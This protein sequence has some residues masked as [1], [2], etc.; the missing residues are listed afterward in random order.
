MK[1]VHR[2][3]SR[4]NLLVFLIVLMLVTIEGIATG[5]FQNNGNADNY[6]TSFKQPAQ[7]AL[8]EP[9]GFR[10]P[11]HDPVIVG[12][13]LNT[14]PDCSMAYPSIDL[15]WPPNHILQPVSIMGATDPDGDPLTITVTDIYQDEPVFDMDAGLTAPDG[16]GVGTSRAE[17]R[18]ERA[19]KGN[20][21]VY[22]VIFT[23]QDTFSNSCS[24]T[25]QIKVPKNRG[26]KGGPFDDGPVYDSTTQPLSLEYHTNFKKNEEKE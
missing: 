8:Y 22:N 25:V 5:D 19:G 16:F 12:L 7:Q 14:A 26:K 6:D 4:E 21:R 24:G 23:A 9:S 13:N 10:S 11:D 2:L 17:V 3:L 1:T 15:L 18:S 20:G